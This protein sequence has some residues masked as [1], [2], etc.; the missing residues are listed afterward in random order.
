MVP[1]VSF[2]A[3]S[4]LRGEEAGQEDMMSRRTYAGRAAAA[5]AAV[6]MAV[7]LAGCGGS[8]VSYKDGTYEGKS[9]VYENPDGSDDGNGYGQ[10]SI[11]IRDGKITDCSFLTYEPDGTLKDEDYGKENGTIANRDFYN[12]AQKAR[13]ACDEYAKALV[14]KGSLDDVDAISGA[15]IN[16]NNFKD[17]V[18][19]A[20][21]KAK[22]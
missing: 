8:R 18:T 3:H 2:A 22:E 14:E 5:A 6:L 17:A 11:T 7:S 21:D 12:K 15:T 1:V 13:A 20:L 10:V 16:Y 9:E 4:G 19:D